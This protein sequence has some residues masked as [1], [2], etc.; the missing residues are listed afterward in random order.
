[1]RLSSARCCG[2]RRLG[3]SDGEELGSQV[4]VER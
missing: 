4:D 1:V 2:E 3:E